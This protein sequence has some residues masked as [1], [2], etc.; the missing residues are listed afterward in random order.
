MET[1]I[2]GTLISMYPIHYLTTNQIANLS[3]FDF[4]PIGGTWKALSNYNFF[5]QWTRLVNYS[6]RVIARKPFET[7]SFTIKSKKF[8]SD[9]LNPLYTSDFPTSEI[10]TTGGPGRFS[11]TYSCGNYSPNRPNSIETICHKSRPGNRARATWGKALHP[12][13]YR[14]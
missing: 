2:L 9:L 8:P 4:V 5:S 11:G 6:Y 12:L 13:T 7:A 1:T 14:N 3:S 10:Q